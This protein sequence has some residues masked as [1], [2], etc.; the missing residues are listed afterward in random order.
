MLLGFIFGFNARLGRL[1]FF[2]STIAAAIVMTVIPFAIAWGAYQDTPRGAPL[3]LDSMK[4]PLVFAVILF[5]WISLTLQSMRVRDI[6]WDPVCVIPGWIAFTIVDKLIA[7]KFPVLSLGHQ[8]HSSI[9]GAVVN[10]VLFLALLFWPSGD[11]DDST[12]TFDTRQKPDRPTHTGDAA[13]R[14][15]RASNGEFGRRTF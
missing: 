14:I 9:I 10:L 11:Y 4:W 1:H 5:G 7:D 3:S 6:G 12:P 8:A 13:S 15:A 2:L